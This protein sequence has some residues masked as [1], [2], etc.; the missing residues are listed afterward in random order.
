MRLIRDGAC[1]FIDRFYIALFSAL[2]QI[3]WQCNLVACHHVTEWVTVAFH[4]MCVGVFFNTHHSGVLTAP[5]GCYMAGA[6]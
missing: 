4:S 2:E 3:Q 6:T 1:L 5:F